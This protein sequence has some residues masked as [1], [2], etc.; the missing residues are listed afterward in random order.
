MQFTAVHVRDQI[1]ELSKREKTSLLSWMALDRRP[2]SKTEQ[3]WARYRQLPGVERDE[4][5]RELARML[6]SEGEG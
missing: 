3:V 1:R 5:Q 6:G 2:M 4:L